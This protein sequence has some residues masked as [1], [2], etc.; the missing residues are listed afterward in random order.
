MP[1]RYSAIFFT[2]TGVAVPLGRGTVS[3][4]IPGMR[5]LLRQGVYLVILADEEYAGILGGRLH[6][7]FDR[8]ELEYLFWGTARGAVQMGF[9]PLGDPSVL[10]ASLP[11]QRARLRLHELAFEFHRRMLWYYHM[12]SRL[13]LDDPERC[14]ID[15]LPTADA[16]QRPLQPGALLQAIEENLAAHGYTKGAGGLLL[17]MADAAQELEI[18]VRSVLHG[19]YLEMS[20]TDRSDS[21]DYFLEQVLRPRGIRSYQCCFWGSDFYCLGDAVCGCDVSMITPLSYEGSFFD[22]NPAG[23]PVPGN[24]QA[25]GGG[26]AAFLD[27]LAAQ[28]QLL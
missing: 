9:D 25:V 2:W 13:L 26:V 24:V 7:W 20:Y 11:D 16:R 17:D 23:E 14:R 22:V 8:H 19:G 12:G 18:P 3:K 1:K 4:A 6:S 27:S 21:V 15:L 5:A 10:R 28:A